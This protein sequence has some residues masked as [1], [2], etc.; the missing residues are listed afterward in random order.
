M[1]GRRGHD[2]LIRVDGAFE[3]RLS[4]HGAD[5]HARQR[6]RGSSNHCKEQ[7]TTN[8]HFRSPLCATDSRPTL[9]DARHDCNTP[10][11]RLVAPESADVADDPLVGGYHCRE[12]L[13]LR[14]RGRAVTANCLGQTLR[15]VDAVAQVPLLA[16]ADSLAAVAAVD[17][18]PADRGVEL[19]QQCRC[20]RP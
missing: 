1:R 5:C 7:R 4:G 6:H 20:A 13:S 9:S 15:A 12:C 10:T 8:L 16:G 14:L 17:L 19:L 3:W 18:P 2:H 11:Q